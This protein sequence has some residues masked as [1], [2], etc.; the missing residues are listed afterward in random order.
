MAEELT[1]CHTEIYGCIA[2]IALHGRCKLANADVYSLR[3]VE[4]I[5]DGIGYSVGEVFEQSAGG[6]EL[7]FYHTEHRRVVDGALNVVVLEG[8]GAY[9]GFYG[10]VYL[11]P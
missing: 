9:I 3:F 2:K 11:I 6:T 4:G 7:V 1:F 5:E 8:R 10:E